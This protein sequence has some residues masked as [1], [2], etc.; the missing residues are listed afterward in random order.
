[1][2]LRPKAGRLCASLGPEPDSKVPP[3]TTDISFQSL[4]DSSADPMDRRRVSSSGIS[5]SI[6]LAAETS[7]LTIT[8]SVSRALRTRHHSEK[9][10]IGM[11]LAPSFCSRFCKSV[12]TCFQLEMFKP[13]PVKIHGLAAAILFFCL[14]L[15]FLF[16]VFAYYSTRIY[17]GRWE[18][19]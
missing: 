7:G 11:L 17:G 4:C 15:F 10:A 5:S 9:V 13:P 16:F 8:L 6:S 1:M 3:G 18:V 12:F 19:V 14:F 2:G